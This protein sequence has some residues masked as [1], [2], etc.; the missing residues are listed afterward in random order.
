MHRIRGMAGAMLALSSGLLAAGAHGE[1]VRQLTVPNITVTAPAPAPPS[2]PP[3]LRG[4][5][6]KAFV[7]NPYFGRFRVDEERFAEVP[8]T[9]TRIASAAGASCLLGYRLSSGI[10]DY[11]LHPNGAENNCDMA[12]DV[13]LYTVGNLSVEANVVILD[14]YKLL[15]RGNPTAEC[16]VE[17]NSGYDETDFQ[18]LNRVTRRGGNWHG[19]RGDGEEKSIAFSD[20]PHD[21]QAVRRPG[22]RWGGGYTYM[23]TAS[24]CRTDA[25]PLQPDDIGR[26]LAP[27]QIRQYDASG[28]LARP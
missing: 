2:Q 11:A 28:N 9:Q 26:A 3:Y 25:A 8:C 15:A 14:P 20:G 17:G 13:T 10:A 18:D 27:L 12:L 23:L 19:L 21:C 24:I 6:A 16:Y 7:R 1:E 22:P 5:A 4:D